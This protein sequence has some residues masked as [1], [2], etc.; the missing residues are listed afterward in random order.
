[1]GAASSW[2]STIAR[3]PVSYFVYS[4][5][6]FFGRK[7]GGELP[8]GWFIAALTDAGRDEAAIRQTLYRMEHEG[9]LVSRRVGRMKFYRPSGYATAEIDAGTEKIFERPQREWDGQWT[10]VRVGLRTAPTAKLRERVIALLAVEGFAQVDANLF[11]HP[12][13]RADRLVEALSPRARADVVIL[14]GK[15]LDPAA[16]ASLVALWKVD[17]LAARYRS[18]LA[19]LS[20]IDARLRAGVSDR[21]AFLMRFA[22]VFDYLGVAWDDPDLPDDVLPPDWPG[23]DARLAAAA[24][25]ERLLP[26]AIRHADT[27]LESIV[28]KTIPKVTSTRK[29]ER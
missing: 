12:R 6:S 13:G 15:L 7:R 27:L 21:D 1:M 19:T 8:G 20:K 10:M 9:E 29:G 14:R 4:A 5:F 3:V 18:V 17:S 16:Q 2:L 22:V 25:Y 28:P 26:A 11:V 23:G 24:L